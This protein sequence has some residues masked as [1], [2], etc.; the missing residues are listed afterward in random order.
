MSARRPATAAAKAGPH[1]TLAQGVDPGAADE[2]TLSRRSR[3]SDVAFIV[4]AFDRSTSK[5]M[6]IHKTAAEGDLPPVHDK[7]N[8]ASAS[9]VTDGERVYA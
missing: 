4:E 9:P 1:P 2:S 7:H 8:L 3:R 5:R 6:W